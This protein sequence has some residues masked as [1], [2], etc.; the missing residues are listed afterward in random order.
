MFRTKR[1]DV[2]PWTHD[3][4]EVMFDVYRRWDVS[5]WL[6]AAP[7][8]PESVEEMHGRVDRWAA[9]AHGPYGI[10]AVVPLETGVPAGTVLLVPLQD[11]TGASLQEVEVGW[12]LHPDAWGHGWATESARGALERAWAAGL[13]EVHAVVLPGNDPSV[14]VTRRL[15]MQPRGRT[16]RYYGIEMD[17]LA[18]GRPTAL[19]T[20]R[21]LVGRPGRLDVRRCPVG[22][23]PRVAWVGRGRE[24]QPVAGPSR[25]TSVRGRTAVA[26]AS[27]AFSATRWTDDGR[28]GSAAR[29]RSRR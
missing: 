24:E 13:D 19:L 22:R 25:R 9:V 12:H 4:V 11:G 8:V 23:L 16:D 27:C 7:R 28:P 1:L 15:G 3:D 6:G 2:R 17:H 18:V 26:P 10:W 29:V 20:G 21:V 5:R 14:A